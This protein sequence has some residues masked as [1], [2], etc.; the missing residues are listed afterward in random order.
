MLPN[1]YSSCSH[2]S[3]T[4][5][6]DF[7]TSQLCR[8]FSNRNQLGHKAKTMDVWQKLEMIRNLV[9]RNLEVKK[10]GGV[11]VTN[12]VGGVCLLKQKVKVCV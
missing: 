1:C 12:K 8:W 6:W 2:F 11:T 4:P 5:L 7:K 9:D 3:I 10:E